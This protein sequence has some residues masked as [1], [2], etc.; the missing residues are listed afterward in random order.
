MIVKSVHG[1]LPGS[2]AQDRARQGPTDR[3]AKAAAWPRAETKLSMKAIVSSRARPRPR[4]D[5]MAPGAFDRSHVFVIN[6]H[7]VILLCNRCVCV[8]VFDRSHTFVLNGGSLGDSLTVL[9]QLSCWSTPIVAQQQL[10]GKAPCF[11]RG[12]HCMAQVSAPPTTTSARAPRASPKGGGARRLG[13]FSLAVF[14]L[15]RRR[16]KSP[17]TVLIQSIIQN[18]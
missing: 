15:K 11:P 6:N 13:R 14:R 17:K 1:K 18:T 10:G 7:V 4:R 2:A 5:M 3:P 9:R 12:A 16:L 8:C